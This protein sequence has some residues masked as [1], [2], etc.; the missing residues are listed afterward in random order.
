MIKLG[1]VMDPISQIKLKKDS[2]FAMLEQAQSRGYQIYYMEMNDLYLEDG[3]AYATTRTI[4]VYNNK[5]HWFDLGEEQTIPLGDLDVILMRKDPPFDTEFIYATYILERAEDAGTLVVNKPQSLRDCNEKLFTAWFA[6]F[7]P[8]TLVTRQTALIK[9]FLQKQHDIIL[10]P[11]DGMGGASIFRVKVDDP[12]L[13]VIIETLTN[14]N[15]QY[16][17]AQT[18]IPAIKEGDKRVL[19]ID[20]QPVPFCLARIPQQGET[21]GNLAAGGHG[22]VRPLSESD[23]AIANAIGPKLKEKGLIFVGL[24][25]IGDKLTEINVTSP[26]CVREIEAANP[27]LSIT[28]MLMDAIETRLNLK[29]K[30]K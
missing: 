26:T 15:R 20:G 27:E 2:S 13:S 28:G 5:D 3:Q 8:R 22:E 14:H 30:V 24:D 6:Q 7:T 12:N 25:I 23:W 21:R 1:I 4:T 19:V 10:K 18:Y 9:Q 16:C 11:L 29:D 17:M